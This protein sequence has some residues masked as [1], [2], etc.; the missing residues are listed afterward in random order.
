[1]TSQEFI[2]VTQ[3]A[4]SVQDAL[5]ALQST[6]ATSSEARDALVAGMG[7]S[8]RAAYAAINA[9]AGW[10]NLSESYTESDFY[11]DEALSGVTS[12]DVVR[13]T[14]QVLAFR[15]TRPFWPV[16]IVV[17]PKQHLPSLTDLGDAPIETLYA[18][19]AVVRELAREVTEEY[20]SCRVLTNLGEYQ[21]SKHLHFH[22]AFGDDFGGN[23]ERGQ[24]PLDHGSA[25]TKRT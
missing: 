20:G 23:L 17:V 19:L 10:T 16:H 5:T 6:T 15:H 7:L 9:S 21:D 4:Q 11:C 22:V 13:E 14:Q 25:F 1:M 18:V 12:I 24:D 2:A 3:A 8:N